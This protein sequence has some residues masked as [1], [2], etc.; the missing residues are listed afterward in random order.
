MISL[1]Q[2]APPEQP[3]FLLA[4]DRE[5]Q[6]TSR[7][8]RLPEQ[9]WVRADGD[10]TTHDQCAALEAV[11]V[12]LANQSAEAHPKCRRGRQITHSQAQTGHMGRKRP[13]YKRT[14]TTIMIRFIFGPNF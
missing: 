10:L 14:I 5:S 6:Y 8:A 7:L 12:A 4:D 2:R 13:I 11:K 9:E 3:L 1:A